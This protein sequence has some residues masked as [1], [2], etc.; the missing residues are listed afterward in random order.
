VR[1]AGARIATVA[2]AIT[3]TIP[4]AA[5]GARIADG[6]EEVRQINVAAAARA[7]AGMATGVVPGALAAGLVAAKI[8]AARGG[9]VRVNVAAVPVPWAVVSLPRAVVSLPRAVAVA[10]GW[11]AAAAADVASSLAAAMAATSVAI[12]LSPATGAAMAPAAVPRAE[13]VSAGTARIRTGTAASAGGG[14]QA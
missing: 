3:R 11:V 8:T 12:L 10:S 2:V 13:D 14:K 9:P 1:N 6:K 4:A 7:T 5:P